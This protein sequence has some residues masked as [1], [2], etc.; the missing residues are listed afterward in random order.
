MNKI[1]KTNQNIKVISTST[2]CLDYYPDKNISIDLIRIKIYINNKE[3]IDGKNIKVDEFY[4]M[5][6]ENNN[7]NIKT[8]QPSL[9]ELLDYF[10]NLAKQGYKKVFVTTIS[11]KLSGSYNVICQAKKQLHD[12]IEIIPYNT[13]TV[14]FSEGYFALEAKRLLEQ[15]CALTEV[16]EHL[17]F[18]K[19]NNTIFFVV[20]SLKQLINNGRLT[21]TKGF[22]GRLLR[23]HPIL[24][25]NENG[26]IVLI[27]KKFTI[28]RSFAYIVD[29][30][31]Q[32]TE[33]KKFVIHILSTGNPRLKTK[34]KTCLEKEL[35]LNN[36]LDIPAT[37]TIGAH[38]GNN[39]L[40]VGII[41]LKS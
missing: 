40:G 29:K 33:N 26:E 11:K 5:M 25:V 14:C 10:E 39:V 27:G 7:L 19:K 34:F 24:Q 28:D 36:I 13:N 31:K 1:N 38:V 2:S 21:K 18:L 30:I 8:S 35:N 23:I 4:N 22:F 17:N 12:K 16:I 32:Y 41:I 15:G 6:N 3:Y 20:N 37:P 9:G